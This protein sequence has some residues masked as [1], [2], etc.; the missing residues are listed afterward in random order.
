MPNF[1][2]II[3]AANKEEIKVP[4]DFWDFW[5]FF[6]THKEKQVEI[7]RNFGDFGEYQRLWSYLVLSSRKYK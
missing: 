1:P 7:A 6:W 2:D 5:Q 3:R 4:E